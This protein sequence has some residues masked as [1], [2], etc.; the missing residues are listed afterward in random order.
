MNV[1]RYLQI[2]SKMIYVKNAISCDT[3]DVSSNPVVVDRGVKSVID[4]EA[5][6]GR[7]L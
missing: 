2:A 3:C 1:K 4:L 7:S 5:G 6:L